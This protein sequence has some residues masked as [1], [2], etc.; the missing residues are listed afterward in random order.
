M[1]PYSRLRTVAP[2]NAKEACMEGKLLSFEP[3]GRVSE[4]LHFSIWVSPTVNPRA[5]PLAVSMRRVVL[6]D[7]TPKAFIAQVAAKGESASP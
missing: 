2:M 6:R 4:T 7:F 3:S 1:C 5:I